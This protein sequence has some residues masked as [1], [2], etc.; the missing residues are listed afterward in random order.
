MKAYHA[1]GRSA[2]IAESYQR[3]RA[4]L[5]AHRGVRPSRETEGLLKAL[6]PSSA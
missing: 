1:L 3:C 6:S 5:A 2:E 4:A